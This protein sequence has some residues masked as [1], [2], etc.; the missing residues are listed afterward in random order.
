M[1]RVLDPLAPAREQFSFLAP[2][3]QRQGLCILNE[4]L[5]RFRPELPVLTAAGY[6]RN[7]TCLYKTLDGT[8]TDAKDPGDFFRGE[9]RQHLPGNL[10]RGR[11]QA[12]EAAV[13]TKSGRPPRGAAGR[14]PN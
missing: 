12:Q 2:G 7:S 6:N 1:T 9:Q 10:H 13:N 14:I 3:L 4:L 5:D 11:G 8:G